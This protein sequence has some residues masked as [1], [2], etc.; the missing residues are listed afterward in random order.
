MPPSRPDPPP[1][2]NT[3]IFLNTIGQPSKLNQILNSPNLQVPLEQG[4]HGFVNSA[5]SQPSKRDDVLAPPY[6][7]NNAMGPLS[8]R[9]VSVSILSM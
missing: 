2:P 7:I 6:T 1:N 3:H 4:R 5:R 8:N 9:T